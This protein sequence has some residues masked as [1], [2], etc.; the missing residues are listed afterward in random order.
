MS[1][2]IYGNPLR[3]GHCEA[4]PHIAEEYPCYVCL[5]VRRQYNIERNCELEHHKLKIA[6]CT[7]T[8]LVDELFN[9][10]P[11][12]DEAGFDPDNHFCEWSIQQERKRLHSIITKFRNQNGGELCKTKQ[13]AE[14]ELEQRLVEA[15]EQVIKAAPSSGPLWH[16]SEQIVEARAAL[17]ALRKKGEQPV[18]SHDWDDQD[19]C[20][21]CGD[22]D[23]YASATCTP[24]TA[25]EVSHD[26]Q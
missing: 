25:E 8:R 16:G 19:K 2:D 18:S 5:E 24:T 7:I 10:F 20:R 14:A 23:W 12:L 26:S 13:S 21:R 22:R 11:L 17:T 6:E 4:H 15:L 3:R 1:W 9:S